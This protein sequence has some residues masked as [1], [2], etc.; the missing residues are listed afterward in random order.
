M[1]ARG[2]AKRSCQTALQSAARGSLWFFHVLEQK[3]IRAWRL[4]LFYNGHRHMKHS[5]EF[6]N[7]LAQKDVVLDYL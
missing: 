5:M 2:N 3:V 1:A 4:E 6:T 7:V